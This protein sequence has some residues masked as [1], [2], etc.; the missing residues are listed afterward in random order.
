MRESKISKRVS[1]FFTALSLSVF[2]LLP[3]IAFGLAGFSEQEFEYNYSPKVLIEFNVPSDFC[4]SKYDKRQQCIRIYL[5]EKSEYGANKGFN[6]LDV[7]TTV[8]MPQTIEPSM[9]IGQSYITGNWFVFDLN[10][11]KIVL[12]DK[13]YN[14]IEQQWEK[15]GNS[16]PEFV[17]TSNY[18]KY[19]RD[20]T[21]D[22]RRQNSQ[23][24][25]IAFGMILA[26]FIGGLSGGLLYFLFKKKRG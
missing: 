8:N 3:N 15:L 16:K 5:S 9:I 17:N 1:A 20:Q 26:F 11:D 6:N 22:S 24:G 19:F 21:E 7:L 12:S 2:L 4:P 13:N 14:T 25:E 18:S 10:N 23:M